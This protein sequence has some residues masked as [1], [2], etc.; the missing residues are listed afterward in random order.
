MPVAIAAVWAAAFHAS[1]ALSP[2]HVLPHAPRAAPLRLQA[3]GRIALIWHSPEPFVYETLY[4]GAEQAPLG[5]SA[6][7]FATL[8]QALALGKKLQAASPRISYT[9]YKLGDGTMELKGS[10]PKRVNA[11]G[12]KVRFRR[13]TP[14]TG[15]ADDGTLLGVGGM[16][17]DIWRELMARDGWGALDDAWSAF[18]RE[19]EL[20]RG[21]EA[22]DEQG[23]KVDFG[24]DEDDDD[25]VYD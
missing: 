14:R 13:R 22:V 18:R 5:R 6:Q 17:D 23:N 2:P 7:R 15:G 11:E 20:G 21:I 8:D 3:G 12:A 16:G 25:P 1:H 19:L 9:V 24:G 4:G 10:Y